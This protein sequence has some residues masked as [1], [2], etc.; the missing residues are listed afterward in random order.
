MIHLLF[1]RRKSSPWANFQEHL[2]YVFSSVLMAGI[3]LEF[4]MLVL[5]CKAS[6]MI[7]DLEITS[8]FNSNLSL[9]IGLAF[10]SR[11]ILNF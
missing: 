10:S 7:T 2:V 9:Q 5:T 8:Y 1:T 6:F 4:T 3:N 11:S